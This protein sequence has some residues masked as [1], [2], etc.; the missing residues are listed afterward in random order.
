M[1]VN[2]FVP[3][4]CKKRSTLVGASFLREK[5]DQIIFVLW[6][7]WKSVMDGSCRRV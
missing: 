2:D 4:I 7:D 3:S 1:F 5:K 6:Q